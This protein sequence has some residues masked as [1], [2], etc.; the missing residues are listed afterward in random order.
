MEKGRSTGFVR[1]LPPFF[2]SVEREVAV[3]TVST[4]EGK[5]L[6]GRAKTVAAA[7]RLTLTSGRAKEERRAS[8][9]CLA[10]VPDRNLPSAVAAI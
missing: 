3:D 10:S 5:S 4:E 6:H 9:A 7:M 2:V 8:R 1:R